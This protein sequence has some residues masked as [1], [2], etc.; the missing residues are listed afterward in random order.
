MLF[1]ID[2]KSHLLALSQTTGT[3]YIFFKTENVHVGYC[4]VSS[5]LTPHTDGCV[6]NK[7]V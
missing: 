3:S 1:K 5:I 6:L 2:E 7:Y 4:D